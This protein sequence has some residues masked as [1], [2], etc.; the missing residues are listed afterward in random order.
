[1]T[2]KVGN[3]SNIANHIKIHDASVSKEHLQIEKIDNETL[4]IT[5]LNSTNGTFIDDIKI[6]E[7]KF[8]RHQNIRIGHQRFTGDQLFERVRMYFLDSK[9]IWVDDFNLLRN[10]FA[11]YE[12]EKARINQTYQTKLIVIRALVLIIIWMIL[13]FIGGEIGIQAEF[14]HLVSIIGGVLAMLIIPKIISNESRTEELS[15]L[16]KR[17]SKVL[18]CPRCS[19]DLSAQP[20]TYWIEQ[21]SCQQCHA[22]WVN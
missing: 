13:Y 7:S 18:A 5:D 12:K 3:A 15:Q 20:Y 4:L 17:Y 1:M 10:K 16:K 8:K 21:R 22:V 11:D 9:V 2:V 19:R 6:K 14:R